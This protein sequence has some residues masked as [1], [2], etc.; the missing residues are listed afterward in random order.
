MKS[1]LIRSAALIMVF[2][3]I[4]GCASTNTSANFSCK[5]PGKSR[6]EPLSQVNARVSI[7]DSEVARPFDDGAYWER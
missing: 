5:G 7:D 2:I 3:G 6:C 1:K 4:T